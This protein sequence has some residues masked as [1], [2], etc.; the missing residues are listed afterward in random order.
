[1][2]ALARGDQRRRFLEDSCANVVERRGQP[3]AAG[4]VV[5]QE[6]GRPESPL[7]VVRAG[8]LSN[9]NAIRY[10]WGFAAG[11]VFINRDPDTDEVWR[12]PVN[13]RGWRDVERTLEKPAG[14]FRIVVLGDSNT[15]GEVVPAE[16]VYTRVTERL[17]QA[18]GYDVEVINISY[19][20]WATDQALEALQHEA[21]KHDPDVIVH[22]FCTND[23]SGNTSVTSPPLPAPKPFRYVLDAE[24][25]ARRKANADWVP[26]LERPKVVSTIPSPARARTKHRPRW[27][28]VSR[29]RRG[30]TSHWSLPS[31][32]RLQ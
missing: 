1:M 5:V 23:L 13:G 18:D 4:I 25:R 15:V 19:G 26:P 24:G 29:Q 32:T 10:G 2:I 28:S 12:S 27:P 16:A 31:S 30:H 11:E 7:E 20:G 9:P 3:D 6:N 17:L 21:L 8:S 22:Q 14:R